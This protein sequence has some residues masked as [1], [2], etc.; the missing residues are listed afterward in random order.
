MRLI[1]AANLR[2]LFVLGGLYADL[3]GALNKPLDL[4]YHRIIE[5]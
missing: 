2:S 5:G 3:E 1:E 4:G